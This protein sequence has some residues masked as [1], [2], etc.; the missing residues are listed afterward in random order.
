L[1]PGEEAGEEATCAARS[2]QGC[3]ESSKA[4]VAASCPAARATNAIARE[5]AG[6]AL[7]AK[8]FYAPFGDIAIK[9]RKHRAALAKAFNAL[10]DISR[11]RKKMF[12]ATSRNL[13][14]MHQC[15]I[16]SRTL[17]TVDRLSVQ[18]FVF[19]LE[20]C[21]RAFPISRNCNDEEAVKVTSGPLL[22]NPR[23]VASVS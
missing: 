4:E 19:L 22:R 21:I 11:L 17:A 20:G 23:C 1:M 16:Q 8:S 3:E 12:V 7:A 14:H 6:L 18:T 5:G 10:R 2:A 13:T 15:F 9:A